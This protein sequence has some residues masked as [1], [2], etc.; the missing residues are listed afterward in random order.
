[1][2]SEKMIAEVGKLGG[3]VEILADRFDGF[4]ERFESK[5]EQFWQTFRINEA[6]VI[7]MLHNQDKQLASIENSIKSYKTAC[8]ER[9]NTQKIRERKAVAFVAFMVTMF[10]QGGIELFRW[11][12]A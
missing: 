3:Q 11:W 5:Q 12:R 6:K 8:D 1:M 4:E 9:F 2:P 7:N 10:Y